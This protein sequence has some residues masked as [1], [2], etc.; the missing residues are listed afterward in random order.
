[1][2]ACGVAWHVDFGND[3]HVAGKRESHDAAYFILR[4]KA[5]ISVRYGGAR[6]NCGNSPRADRRQ[7]RIL[8]NLQTPTLIVGEVPMQHIQFVPAHP[9]D[10]RAHESS[11][12]E[13]NAATNPASVRASDSGA[14]RRWF[15]PRSCRRPG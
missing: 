8:E 9:I 15:A 13:E 4:I 6:N 7:T 11:W 5:A 1:M 10:H 14:H 12:I 3:L 2:A